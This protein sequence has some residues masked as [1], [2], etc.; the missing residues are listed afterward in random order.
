V[1]PD[2]AVLDEARALA[3]KLLAK[4]QLSLATTK[5]GTNA[6]ANLMVPREATYSDAELLLLAEIMAR[7]RAERG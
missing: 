5:S 7:R 2:N 3:K 6:L 4:D 1:Y